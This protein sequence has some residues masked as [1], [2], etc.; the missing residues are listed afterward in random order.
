MTQ[1]VAAVA[2]LK[3]VRDRSRP[4]LIAPATSRPS[5]RPTPRA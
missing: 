3:C 4:G 2:A 5:P 1:F